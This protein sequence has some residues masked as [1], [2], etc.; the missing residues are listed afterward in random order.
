MKVLSREIFAKLSESVDNFGDGTELDI[1]GGSNPMYDEDQMVDLLILA[2]WD[3]W[4]ALETAVYDSRPDL[5]VLGQVP[6]KF[7]VD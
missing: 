3:F 1:T 2:I 5:R 7:L 6:I 4:Q